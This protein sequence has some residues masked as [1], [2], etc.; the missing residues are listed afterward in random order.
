[1]S[2][3]GIITGVVTAQSGVTLM[4]RILGNSGR[5]ITQ[6]SLLSI[7]YKVRDLF[8]L[9]SLGT[10]TFTIS[11]T[12][13]DDLQQG[14]PRWTRDSEHSPGPDFAHGYNFLATLPASLFPTAVYDVDPET[15]DVTR[16]RLQVDVTFTPV[17]GEPWVQPFSFQPIPTY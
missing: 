10:G 12:V 4:A 17:T 13:F 5:P 11:T 6:A 3:I 1:M 8:D 2:T 15:G 16:H 9:I 14:D 7:T